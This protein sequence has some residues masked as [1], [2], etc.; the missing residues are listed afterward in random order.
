M[1]NVYIKTEELNKWITKHLPSREYV[2]VDDLIG[3]IEDLDSEVDELRMQIEE[4]E[5]DMKDNYRPITHSEQ[6]E[7]SD[8]DFYVK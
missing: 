2:T 1:D 7:I 8:S 6:Y 3:A 4:I 5:N